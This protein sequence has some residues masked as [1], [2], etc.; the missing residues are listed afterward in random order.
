[1]AVMGGGLVFAATASAATLADWEMNEASGAKV[2][3]DSSGHVSGTIGSA[4][5]TGVNTMGATAYEWAF[6]SPTA[7]P[8]KPQRLVQANS[9]T[10]NPGASNYTVTIRYKTT[11]ISATSSRRARPAPRGAISSLRTPAA[12]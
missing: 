12:T 4:V 9:A 5:K 6:T 11:S 3:V 7:P 8:A 2:M 10:L 1:M